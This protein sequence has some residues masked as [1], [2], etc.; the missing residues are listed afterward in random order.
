M[1]QFTA[2]FCSEFCGGRHPEGQAGLGQIR[3]DLMMIDEDGVAYL[4]SRHR[5]ERSSSPQRE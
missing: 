3:L 2:I 4:L 1:T 5:Y